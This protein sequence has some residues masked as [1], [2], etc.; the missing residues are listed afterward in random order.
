[1]SAD[2]ELSDDMAAWPRDPFALLGVSHRADER[3]ARRAYIKLIRRFKPEHA[4][5]H[6]QRIR[7][8]FE[9]V[10]RQLEVRQRYGW[11]SDDDE[12]SDDEDASAASLATEDFA[13]SE[14]AASGGDDPLSERPSIG[15][16]AGENEAE[17]AE[18]TVE[19]RR[20]SRSRSQVF[21]AVLA[22]PCE[23]IW[24][25]AIAGHEQDAY[26]RLVSL[27]GQGHEV[28][29]ASIRAYWLLSLF[30]N[31]DEQRVPCDWLAT[32][33]RASRLSG[34]AAELYRREMTANRDEAMSERC[35]SLLETPS[36]TGAL[37]DLL[38][39]RW[40]AL[41]FLQRGDLIAGD[42]PVVRRRMTLDDDETWARL[43]LM[44]IDHLAWFTNEASTRNAFEH[45][46]AE[47]DQL[48]H[49]HVRFGEELDR[50]DLLTEMSG[51]WRR[52]QVL[53]DVP[54]LWSGI[55]PLFWTQEFDSVRPMLLPVLKEISDRPTESLATLDRLFE[56]SR[57]LTAQIAAAAAKARYDD[58]VCDWRYRSWEQTS[59]RVAE[60]FRANAGNYNRLRIPLLMF[61][62]REV[63]DPESVG[64]AVN[65]FAK[66][67]N[68]EGS[69]LSELI[70]ADV[71]LR[72]VYS[73]Y[74]AIRG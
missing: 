48:A 17:A 4:P 33:L 9:Y 8:A 47:L 18:A 32:A 29:A 64:Q 25:Q 45:C 2:R 14:P 57:A 63:V 46:L 71:P 37:V 31:L 61:C 38:E 44:A 43:L 15:S 53:I 12:D 74:R 68:N 40:R 20:H 16:D 10:Q 72:I 35:R 73:A 30:P 6:F 1:M 55:A 58:S 3:E 22:D 70:Q 26:A 67:K 36:D 60:F 41:S 50:L 49:L 7:E 19:G 5:D 42:L 69:N 54:L 11:Y 34:P 52:A 28:A 59:E 27:V 56:C 13:E 24:Q 23:E 62:L 65:E 21:A 39:A 66:A 51:A